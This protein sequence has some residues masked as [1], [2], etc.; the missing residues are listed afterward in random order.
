MKNIKVTI[1]MDLGDQ[2]NIVVVLDEVS[3]DTK[4]DGKND[5]NGPEK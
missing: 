5:K 4:N 2:N 3:A 1:G